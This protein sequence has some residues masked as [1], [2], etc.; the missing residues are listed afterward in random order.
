M[1]NNI[2]PSP[3]IF[4]VKSKKSNSR[5][6]VKRERERLRECRLLDCFNLNIMVKG[7]LNFTSYLYL[8]LSSETLPVSDCYSFLP[9][10]KVCLLSRRLQQFPAGNSKLAI[11]S[12][13]H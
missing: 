3:Y 6:G 5:E 11:R 8:G 4:Y 7:I 13:D 2:H 12:S 9:V 1:L 10:M